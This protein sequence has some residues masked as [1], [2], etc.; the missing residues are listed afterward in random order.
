MSEADA[1]NGT[2]VDEDVTLLDQPDEAS[3][4]EDQLDEDTAALLHELEDSQRDVQRMLEQQRVQ[5]EELGAMKEHLC[6]ELQQLKDDAWR[7]HMNVELEMLKR[8]LAILNDLDADLEDMEARLDSESGEPEQEVMRKMMEDARS[9][10]IAMLARKPQSPL[11]TDGDGPGPS[12]SPGGGGD[13]GKDP[14]AYAEQGDDEELEISKM[15][16]CLDKDFELMQKQ[17]QFVRAESEMIA[18][19][20][21]ELEAELRKLMEEK[22][23]DLSEQLGNL[24]FGDDQSSLEEEEEEADAENGLGG[25][26]Y[27][28]GKC[29]ARG[30]V[31][32]V[33]AEAAAAAPQEATIGGPGSPPP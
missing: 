4:N 1:V 17:L 25:T 11:A 19:K 24:G 20:K 13:D 32:A 29:G 21:A 16:D 22:A 23:D 7:F 33:V 5:A 12:K 14:E 6:A 3:G 10:T 28:D 9:A 15:Q 2:P 8:Q 26:E 27:A 31:D 18:A 30:D